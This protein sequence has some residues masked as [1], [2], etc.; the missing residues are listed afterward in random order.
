MLYIC[1]LSPLLGYNGSMDV[2]MRTEFPSIFPL[3]GMVIDVSITRN[4]NSGTYG[5]AD[6]LMQQDTQ[7]EYEVR[8]VDGIV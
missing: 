6:T 4:D 1:T 5:Q 8:S 3:H 2:Y 7:T